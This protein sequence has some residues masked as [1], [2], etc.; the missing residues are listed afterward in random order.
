MQE[1]EYP[2]REE[3]FENISNTAQLKSLLSKEAL[4]LKLS[5]QYFKISFQKNIYIYARCRLCRSSLKYKKIDQ[6]YQLTSYRN[7]HIHQMSKQTNEIESFIKSMP[8]TMT[9]QSLMQITRHNF[10]IST[11]KFYFFVLF[12][13]YVC[14]CFRGTGRA[15][16]KHI[17]YFILVLY[18]FRDN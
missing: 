15:K 8:I 13:L 17:L 3:L 1:F 10:N 7:I 14:L 6:Q 18:V 9:T 5:Q 2:L 11:S 4:Y 12:V 16:R